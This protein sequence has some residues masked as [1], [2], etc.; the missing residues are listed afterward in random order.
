MVGGAAFQWSGCPFLGPVLWKAQRLWG[1]LWAGEPG[2]Q[3]RRRLWGLPAPELPENIPVAV[4]LVQDRAW[5]AW[6]GRKWYLPECLLGEV[7]KV[8]R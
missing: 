6:G 3:A 8:G 4:G 5:A 7:C 2:L 1:G